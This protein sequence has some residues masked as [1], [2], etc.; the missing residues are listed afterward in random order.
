M[1]WYVYIL[2]LEDD[3]LYTGI[4]KDIDRRIEEHE[5]GR[6]SK[7]VRGRTPV[8]LVHSEERE[9]MSEALK[10]EAEIKRWSKVKKE[11]FVKKNGCV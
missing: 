4:T 7:Y 5:D 9:T 10:R 3:S 11:D 1:M 6:G 8:E 2:R